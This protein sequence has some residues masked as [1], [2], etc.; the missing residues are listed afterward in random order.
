[1]NEELRGDALH[2]STETE[3]QH[4]NRESKKVQR[5]LS[6]ELPDWLQEF[7]ENLVLQQSLGETQSRE[8]KTLPSHLM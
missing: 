6:H 4:K 8:V 3:K 2:D 1:M 5:D 7:R